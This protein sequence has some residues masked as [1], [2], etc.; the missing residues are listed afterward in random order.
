MATGM[1][2]MQYHCTYFDRNYLVRGLALYESLNDV[3]AT[4][5]LW[6]LCLDDESHQALTALAW[7]GLVPVS[8]ADLEAFDPELA[9]VRPTRSRIEYYFTLT[10]ALPTY[11]LAQN[12]DVDVISYL[13]ADLI[14]Y[15]NPSVIL[16]ELGAGSTIIIPHGFPEQLRHLEAYGKFNVGMV[17]FRNDERG[18]AC[19]ARWR[20]RCIEWC[21]D[22]AEDGRFADQGYLDDWPR[23]H[24]GVVILDRPGVGLGPWNFMRFD[25]DVTHDPPLVDGK[26]LVYFHF[27]NFKGLTGRIF[28]DGLSGYG[29]M[30]QS[31][32]RLLY[33]GYVRRL[34]R[35]RGEVGGYGVAV[36]RTTRS[37]S[38]LSVRSV[39]RLAR[40]RRLLV[41]IGNRVIG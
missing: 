29:H 23:V 37:S 16:D 2:Q 40:R 30:P 15:A 32:R 9:S 41:G 33:G 12:P 8:V 38:R 27:H 34:R 4:F 19:L 35:L 36:A 22:R 14:F 24:E 26:P 1:T 5:T 3:G 6:A 17:T 28:D 21:Y 11:L 7:P 13:D 39:L 31:A 18:R 10:P 20:Q 25:L